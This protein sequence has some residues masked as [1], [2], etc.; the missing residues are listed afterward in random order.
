MRLLMLTS[1]LPA[2]MAAFDKCARI[3]GTWVGFDQ[4]APLSTCAMITFP[5]LCSANAPMRRL[6][7]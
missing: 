1:L 2:A 3:T 4:V 5:S 7:S 6:R